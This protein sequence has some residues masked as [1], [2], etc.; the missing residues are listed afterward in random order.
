MTAH[1]INYI[2]KALLIVQRLGKLSGIIAAYRTAVR[3]GPMSKTGQSRHF[4]RWPTTSGLSMETDIIRAGRHV[5]KS[6]RK[7]HWN[8]IRTGPFIAADTQKHWR[9]WADY[10]PSLCRIGDKGK[11]AGAQRWLTIAR[12]V[13]DQT[14]HH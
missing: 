6:A 3:L 2:E 11:R 14:E 13:L 4:G 5:A 8:A 9:R 10:Y 12:S 7:R 1:G